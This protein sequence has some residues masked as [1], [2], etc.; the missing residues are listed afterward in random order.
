M[1]REFPPASDSL[2]FNVDSTI[3]KLYVFLNSTE[4]MNASLLYPDGSLVAVGSAPRA[5]FE[6]YSSG[7]IVLLDEIPPGEWTFQI[8]TRGLVSVAVQGRSSIRFG[9]FDYVYWGG[10]GPKIPTQCTTDS[11][12]DLRAQRGY[13]SPIIP[14]SMVRDF[15]DWVREIGECGYLGKPLDWQRTP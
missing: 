10:C 3:K 11:E 7:C 9:S 5:R 12:I 8:E 6:Q 1:R 13:K 2:S 14:E 4:P 15:A